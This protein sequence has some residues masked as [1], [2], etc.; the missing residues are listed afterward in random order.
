MAFALACQASC[1]I[2]LSCVRRAAAL[3][4]NRTIGREGVGAKRRGPHFSYFDALKNSQLFAFHRC[5]A[6]VLFYR[7]CPP[8]ARRAR[9][10]YTSVPPPEPHVWLISTTSCYQ[11]YLM[12]HFDTHSCKLM[13]Y[14]KVFRRWK[15][16]MEKSH[17]L[18][19]LTYL[20]NVLLSLCRWKSN[21]I[22]GKVIF[23]PSY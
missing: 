22:C 17:F 1:L 14:I 15:V 23:V 7:F 21:V 8:C 5:P 11:Y 6:Y 4:G 19:S 9:S 12:R 16:A 18:S 13:L 2:K 20:N 10:R 3:L